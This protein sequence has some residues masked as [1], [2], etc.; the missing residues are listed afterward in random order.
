MVQC[1]GAPNHLGITASLGG[2]DSGR[3]LGAFRL[4]RADV[5]GSCHAGEAG[6][7]NTWMEG[8]RGTGATLG[9][10]VFST[11]FRLARLST[12]V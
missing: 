8:L 10:H 1:K 11:H 9:S 3:A 2:D 4:F 6:G 5:D 12:S 7:P